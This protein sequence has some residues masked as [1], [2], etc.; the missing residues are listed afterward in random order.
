L[1]IALA[2][3]ELATNAAKYGALSNDAGTVNVLW[4]TNAGGANPSF[5]FE[6]IE[7]GGP[8]V[9]QPEQS[10]RG[11]GTRLIERMLKNDFGGEVL[12][13]FKPDG[14]VWT[15]SA[16]LEKLTTPQYRDA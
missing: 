4:K 1:A 6:W 13:D 2:I 9:V 7:E 15:L 5:H 10:K 12:L 16:P 14:L 3:H 8:P 11:F